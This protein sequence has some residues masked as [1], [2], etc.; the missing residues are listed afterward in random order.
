M[1]A[2]RAAR[3]DNGGHKNTRAEDSMRTLVLALAAAACLTGCDR[4]QAAFTPIPDRINAAFP[5]PDEVELARKRLAAALEAD[6]AAQ[7]AAGAQFAQLMNVRALACSA[8][9]PV[10]RFDTV[11]RIRG[12][13]TDVQCFT[14]QDAQLDEWIA[15]R[16]IGVALR[17]P[18]LVPAAPLPARVLLPTA[19]DQVSSAHLAAQ[20]NVLVLRSQQK[21]QAL[22]V[23]GGK[24]ISNFS[25][26]GYNRPSLSPNGRLL[27]VPGV[28]TLRVVD[29]ESGKVLWTTEKFDNLVGWAPEAELV[30]LL[31]TGTGAP[32][33]LDTRAGRFDPYP[34]AEKRLSWSLPAGEGRMLVGYYNSAS[35]MQHA[36][37][38][39]GEIQVQAVQQWTLPHGALSTTPFLT[40]QG[41]RLVYP[42]NQDLAWLDL[43][44]GQQGKWQVSALG[45]SNF[46]QVTDTRIAF[47]VPAPDGSTVATRLLDTE[48]GTI[49][50]AKEATDRGQVFPLVPRPGFLRRS[51]NAFALVGTLEGDEPQDA[52]RVIS[53]ALVAREIAKLKDPYRPDFGAPN[54]GRT[55]EQQAMIEQL[56]RQVRALNAQ[57]AIR[58][59]LPRETIDAIRRGERPTEVGS[60][61]SG[62]MPAAP[63]V[64]KTILDVPPDS[65][66]AMLGVYQ[67]ANSS[68]S[69]SRSGNVS[70]SVAPGKEPLVLV[71]TSY[72]TV[73]WMIHAG[74]RRIAAVLI[75]GYKPSTVYG[76]GS[77]QV[78]RIGSK[79]AYKIDSHD[80]QDLRREIARYVGP[81]TPVF[82]GVYEG[83]QFQVQ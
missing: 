81:S 38:A 29:V 36:R 43:A 32:T 42:A 6:K 23:P 4:M 27:A 33:M 39:N 21:A 37:S 80:F 53:E 59:G 1:F 24:E 16:R 25:V 82:Q 56:S 47:D 63:L 54:P 73:N 62:A 7:E 67:A 2:D 66:I 48:K 14:K 26:D 44:S 51:S 5:L 17:A 55:P 22:Q 31:Q 69:A 70:V 10:G 40:N 79:H 20:A 78:V 74:N 57:A 9:A 65:R 64:G 68:K 19:I 71:L 58:D 83:S 35:L 28:K 13:L 15:V 75:S 52:E 61:S 3:P 50:S 77:A 76:Q 49:A 60:A 8:A 11:S 72:E 30:V 46:A 34:T 41:K 12:K 45:A 18:P